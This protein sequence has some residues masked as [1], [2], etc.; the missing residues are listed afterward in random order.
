MRRVM[1]NIQLFSP[2]VAVVRPQEQAA[3]NRKK[4]RMGFLPTE[5]LLKAITED[6]E[7][8]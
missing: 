2:D 7:R 5:S 3:T 1:E 4:R 6:R 8:W